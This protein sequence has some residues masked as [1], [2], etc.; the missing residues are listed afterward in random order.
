MQH[1]IFGT[2]RQGSFDFTSKCLN[3]LLEKDFSCAGQVHQIVGVDHERL[4]IVLISQTL[5]LF[6]LRTPKLV[7]R[8][9]SRTGRENLKSITAEPV[10]AFGSVLHASGA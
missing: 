5:H 10:S 2:E 3:R 1:Q 7:W 6:A 9:P 4:Q 8:P